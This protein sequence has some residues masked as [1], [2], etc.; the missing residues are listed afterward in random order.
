MTTSDQPTSRS[1]AERDADTK[2][3]LTTLEGWR[4]FVTDT[5]PPP[6]L[7]T[8]LEHQALSKSAQVLDDENRID[9]H[10]RTLVVA[11]PA[12]RHIVTCGRRQ[13]LMNRHERGARRGLLVSGPAG[14]GNGAAWSPPWRTPSGSAV[15]GRAACAGSTAGCIRT[16]AE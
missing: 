6:P 14:T 15:T 11:T 2:L 10:A 16:P 4:D 3:Q 1:L 13:V 9:Y 8:E 5:P 7:L 12:I